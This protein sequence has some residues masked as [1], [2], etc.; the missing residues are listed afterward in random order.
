MQPNPISSRGDLMASRA[1]PSPAVAA[2]EVGWSGLTEEL[3]RVRDALKGLQYGTVTVVVQDGVVVQ[4]DRTE[5]IRL[6]RSANGS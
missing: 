1:N 3:L 5:K 6:S 4:I 2:G